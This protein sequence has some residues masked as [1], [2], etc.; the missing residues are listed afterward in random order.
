MSLSKYL[1][2][3]HKASTDHQQ[4]QAL[5]PSP[6]TTEL[7]RFPNTQGPTALCTR[8][9]ALSMPRFACPVWVASLAAWADET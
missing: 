9:D 5:F 2:V 8:A 1:L 4:I 7:T 3:L 6:A